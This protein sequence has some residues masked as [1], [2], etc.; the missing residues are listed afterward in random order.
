MGSKRLQVAA[1][2]FFIVTLL[3]V[4][5]AAN[6]QTA[7]TPLLGY[8]AKKPVFGGACPLCPWGS[9]ADVVKEA[10]KGTGWDIQVC[11]VC[12][13]G[14]RSVRMVEGKQVPPLNPK[15][16]TQPNPPQAPVDF[17]ATGS[18]RLWWAYQGILSH[19]EDGAM[20]DLRLIANIQ[21]PAWYLVAVRKGSGISD[22]RQI[23]EKR[24]KVKFMQTGIQSEGVNRL[25][26]YFNLSKQ[27]IESDLGGK[28]VDTN[29]EERQ[30]VDVLA[31]WV[32]LVQAPEY[33]YWLQM[34]ERND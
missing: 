19:K 14:A 10:M 32:S 24:L 6:A 15:D 11:Y 22:L 21:Q 33:S 34:A 26:D 20:K 1:V 18:E 28:L 5:Q 13:G 8:A 29:P 31:G 2:V 3:A 17:G 23:R 16:T 7:A 27:V 30:N 12:A 25:L 9:M 4:C